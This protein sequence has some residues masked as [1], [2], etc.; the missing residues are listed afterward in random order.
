MRLSEA[1]R[2][3]IAEGVR[4]QRERSREA[5]VQRDDE[6]GCLLWTGRLEANGYPG[7][8]GR[9]HR[10]RLFERRFGSLAGHGYRLHLAHHCGR[11]QCI[12]PTHQ[13]LLSAKEHAEQ[14]RRLRAADAPSLS[15][16]ELIAL[17]RRIA[18]ALLIERVHTPTDD[19]E[20]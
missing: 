6:T 8:G 3:R 9:L 20:A 16:N 5:Q 18:A 13:T 1:H 14:H 7:S 11:R 19:E 17:S 4:R 2:A 10:E 12:E 15:R